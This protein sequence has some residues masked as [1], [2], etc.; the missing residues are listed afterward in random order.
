MTL[1]APSRAKREIPGFGNRLPRKKIMT[2]KQFAI[3]IARQ[4]GKIIRKNFKVGMEKKYKADGSPVTV[5]DISVNKLVI[6]EAKRY[7]PTHDVLGEEESYRI[8]HGKYLWVCDPVDGTVPFSHGI[9]T[10]VFSLAL[11]RDGK[12]IL[13]VIYDPM[14]D[15]MFFAEFGK[16]ATLNGRKIRVNNLSMKSGVIGWSNRGMTKIAKF[17]YPK[18]QLICLWCI[19]YEG[20]MVACGELN[21][22]CYP[23]KNA[24]DVAALKVIVE[25]AGGKVTDRCGREQRYDGPI[26]GALITNGKVHKELLKFIR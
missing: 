26:N 7:F 14:M 13:G 11:V 25:E 2:Y 3:K 12:P 1:K 20:A 15:R 17:Y 4:A 6:A 21:A 8:N 10:L 23:G 16:G 22:T 5:T 19:C 24:H 18:V 9:P